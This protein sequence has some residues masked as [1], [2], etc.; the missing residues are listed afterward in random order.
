M[1]LTDHHLNA[2]D[3]SRLT[4]DTGS[5]HGT[6]AAYT[7]EENSPTLHGSFPQFARLASWPVEPVIFSNNLGSTTL[8][9]KN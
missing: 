3:Q 5:Q 1:D 2:S 9:S 8:K 6:L 7:S 4:K